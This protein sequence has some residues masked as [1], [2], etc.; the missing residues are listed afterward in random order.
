MRAE[1]ASLRGINDRAERLRRDGGGAVEA[2]R[3][4]RLRPGG[5]TTHAVTSR[6]TPASLFADTILRMSAREREAN[7]IQLARRLRRSMTDAEVIL[8]SHLR[9]DQFRRLRFRRQH[10]IGPYVA[11]FVCTKRKFVIEVDGETHHTPEQLLHDMRRRAYLE[12]R[13]WR[14][15]RVT[16]QDVY[17]DLDGVLETIWRET[18]DT[19]HI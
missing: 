4:N 3:G 8:W 13:G 7:T 10:P 2:P 11:D 5:A 17:D 1:V 14:E 19:G 15:M 16:N 12:D 18:R 9:R 6:C